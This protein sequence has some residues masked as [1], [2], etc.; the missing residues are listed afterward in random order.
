MASF[1]YIPAKV[2]LWNGN[3]ILST[4][5]IRTIVVMSNTTADTDTTAT[6]VADFGTLDEYDGTNYSRQ[7]LASEAVNQD[8]PNS[9]AEFDANDAAYGT[10]G[11]PLSPG[12]R[13]VV[14]LVIFR[15]V[16]NDADSRV[17][18]FID[19][20]PAFSPRGIITIQWNAEGIAHLT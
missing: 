11:L 17:I 2:G 10:V 8:T 15:F 14:G 20:L 12:T 4:H 13:S 7:A 9:R 18:F 1:A 5:D 16:T 3:I 19:L 6:F